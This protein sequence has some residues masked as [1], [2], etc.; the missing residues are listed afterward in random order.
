MIA[1]RKSKSEPLTDDL[2]KEIENSPNADAYL[3]KHEDLS[4]DLS[5][6][7]N[8]LLGV[9][10]IERRDVVRAS[11]VNETYAW[12]IFNGK[13]SNPDRN[14]VLQLAFGLSATLK[15][16]QHLLIYADA[17]ALY[18]KNRRDAIIIYAL[19]HGLDLQETDEE[20]SRFGEETISPQ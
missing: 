3:N 8:E 11:G 20:L 15:E 6:Y 17:A 12:E 7:L 16:T 13:K 18:A 19:T 14:I 5:S 1:A 4:Q 9:H 10:Q 2:L